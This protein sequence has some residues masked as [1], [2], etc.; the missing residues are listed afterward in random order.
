M[1][2][3][4]EAERNRHQTL[5]LMALTI[6]IELSIQNKGLGTIVHY[7]PPFDLRYRNEALSH[8]I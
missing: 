1:F 6:A 7:L 2:G 8:E 4:I 5:V 3:V